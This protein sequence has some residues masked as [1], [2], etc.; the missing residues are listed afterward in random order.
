MRMNKY[1]HALILCWRLHGLAGFTRC[2]HYVDA[3]QLGYHLHQA[4]RIDLV[5]G[6]KQMKS[7]TL[8][9]LAQVAI[10]AGLLVG[11]LAYFDVLTK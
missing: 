8:D 9:L 2:F 7:K 1:K 5:N 4:R 3:A 6:V 10:G 11:L